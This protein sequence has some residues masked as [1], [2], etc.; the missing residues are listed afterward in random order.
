[1]TIFLGVTIIGFT[2]HWL[3]FFAFFVPAGTPLGLVPV[4]VLIEIISYIARAFSLGLRIIANILAG[5][6]LI[7]I[8]ASFLFTL[9][10]YNYVVGFVTLI[11]FTIFV[12]LIVLELAIAIIQT[13]V[14]VVL[15]ASYIKDAVLIHLHIILLDLIPSSP[16]PPLPPS[17][18]GWAKYRVVGEA[19][20]RKIVII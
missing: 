20:I 9:F 5:H 10:T 8:L 1:M 4:L 2:R 15:T 18:G 14:F 13:Y 17:W 6:L 3:H 11:P 19:I 7:S 12:G 16:P